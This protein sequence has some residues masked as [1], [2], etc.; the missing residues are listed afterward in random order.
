MAGPF[1]IPL[2]F[3]FG[4]YKYVGPADCYVPP[5]AAVLVY[6]RR[7]RRKGA[8]GVSMGYHAGRLTAAVQSEL[9]RSVARH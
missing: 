6:R 2:A 3:I 4:V 1:T 5:L 7:S 8:T 9:S